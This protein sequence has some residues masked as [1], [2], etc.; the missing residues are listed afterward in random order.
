LS[1]LWIHFKVEILSKIK[2]SLD[3]SLIS[4]HYEF[5]MPLLNL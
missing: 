3:L 1:R 5:D 4:V 2:G